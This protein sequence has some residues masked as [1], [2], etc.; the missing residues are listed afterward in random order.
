VEQMRYQSFNSIRGER[1]EEKM[2]EGEIK[3]GLV[4]S[5]RQQSVCDTSDAEVPGRGY[6]Y[7]NINTI[8]N[9][10]IH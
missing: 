10:K 8:D 5:N 3:S 1:A 9:I 6:C 2:M 7:L 4:G